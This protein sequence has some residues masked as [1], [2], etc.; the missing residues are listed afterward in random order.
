MRDM[1]FDR[2]GEEVATFCVCN[3]RDHAY[4]FMYMFPFRQQPYIL[5]TNQGERTGGRCVGVH[6]MSVS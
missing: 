1:A 4:A 6:S 2:F 3:S 5:L